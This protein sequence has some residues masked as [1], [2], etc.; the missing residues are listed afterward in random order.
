MR[1][2]II[3]L[4]LSLSLSCKPS[5][6]DMRFQTIQNVN[7]IDWASLNQDGSLITMGSVNTTNGKET[8]ILYEIKTKSL[9]TIWESDAP[10][11]HAAFHP[12]NPALVACLDE[13]SVGLV[14]ITTG[15]TIFRLTFDFEY[16]RSVGFSIDGKL[17]FAVV[18]NLNPK[19]PVDWDVRVQGP[20][21]VSEIYKIDIATHALVD[22]ISIENE[23]VTAANFSL[24]RNYVGLRYLDGKADIWDLDNNQCVRSVVHNQGDKCIVLLDD[25]TFLTDAFPVKDGTSI[26]NVVMW[27]EKT[28]N[29]LKKFSP[30]RMQ[31]CNM[32]II[33]NKNNEQYILS[34]GQDNVVHLWSLDTGKVI[35]SKHD[36][37][38]FY[39]VAV[40]GNRH[41]AVINAVGSP[42]IIDFW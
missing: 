29:V 42:I 41:R 15:N 11:R 8:I 38:W 14:D 35:W 39:V 27:D 37:K 3:F 31:L 22:K 20:Y 24:T 33:Q 25:G 17:L 12:S 18:T 7:T 32:G 34:G 23:F 36:K 21:D 16:A 19:P 40:S 6:V 10:T 2:F 1:I 9:Q 5:E 30:H 4:L 26:A 13:A 28:G